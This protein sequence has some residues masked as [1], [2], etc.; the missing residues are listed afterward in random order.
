MKLRR[1]I[2]VFAIAALFLIAAP[3]SASAAPAHKGILTSAPGS[4]SFSPYSTTD[5]YVRFYSPWL[6]PTNGGYEYLHDYIVIYT[7]HGGLPWD[8]CDYYVQYNE[9]QYTYYHT[10]GS[11]HTALRANACGAVLPPPGWSSTNVLWTDTYSYFPCF[12][13]D[14]NSWGS[15]FNGTYGGYAAVYTVASI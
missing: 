1:F 3:V 5:N 8:H 15:Y 7:G 14:A 4:C 11:Y 2:G 10:P 13:S 12:H 6:Y 9:G